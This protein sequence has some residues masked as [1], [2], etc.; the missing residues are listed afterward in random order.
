MSGEPAPEG[1]PGPEDDAGGRDWGAV[2]GGVLVG[3]LTWTFAMVGVAMATFGNTGP[4]N[5]PLTWVLVAV[6]LGAVGLIVWP[7][8]RRVGKGLL[9]G[10]AI[11]LVVAG[12]ICIPLVVSGG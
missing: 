8:T 2:G 1:S 3:F 6:F 12:G 10:V 4:A 5:G 7:R 11:G 9:L